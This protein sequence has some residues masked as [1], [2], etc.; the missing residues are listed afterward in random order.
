MDEMERILGPK[1]FCAGASLPPHIWRKGEVNSR[2][3][4][5]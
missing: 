3:D 4:C 2:G 5:W 1:S